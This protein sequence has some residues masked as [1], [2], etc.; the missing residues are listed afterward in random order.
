MSGIQESVGR[1][2]LFEYIGHG[3]FHALEKKENNFDV[4]CILHIE[5]FEDNLIC[6]SRSA[7]SS[8]DIA[9]HCQHHSF[10]RSWYS[11][12]MCV[13]YW[14]RTLTDLPKVPILVLLGV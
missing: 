5:V 10:H 13:Q 2:S 9:R 12:L 4:S 7:S 1:L 11:D 6:R 3:Q 8:V 14:N